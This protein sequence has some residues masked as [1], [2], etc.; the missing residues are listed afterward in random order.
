MDGPSFTQFVAGLIGALFGGSVVV[1]F[2]GYY[3][4]KGERKLL[5]EELPRI[6]EEE[7]QKAYAQEQGKRLATHD[8][9]EHVL[10]ELRMV[11]KETETIKAKIGGDLW[12]RQTVWNRRYDLYAEIFQALAELRVLVQ[13]QP[14]SKE[15]WKAE[16]ESMVF[17]LQRLQRLSFVFLGNHARKAFTKFH[18]KVLEFELE[19]LGDTLHNFE[20]ALIVAARRDLGVNSE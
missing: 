3:S 16:Y 20:I 9:I 12:L 19:G 2:S 13:S 6:L 18:G 10:S 17:R 11:T 5:R 4:K 7:R 14:Q 15:V 8:D 1:Y